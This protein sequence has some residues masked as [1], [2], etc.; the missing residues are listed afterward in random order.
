MTQ[1]EDK[2]RFD[3][4]LPIT[5]AISTCN[6]FEDLGR[7]LASLSPLRYAAWSILVVDQSDDH[8]A[9]QLAALFRE[10]SETP[11]RYVHMT[12]KGLSRA[13]NVA[14][15]E[16][17]DRIIA[18]L[19]DDCTVPLDWLQSIASTYQRHPT[20]S[21]VYGAVIPEQIDDDS[22]IPSHSVTHE[23]FYNTRCWDGP[24][25]FGIG[26]SFT[27][28]PSQIPQPLLFDVHLGA[29]ADFYGSDEHDYTLRA[30]DIGV[31][32]IETP[33]ISV[34]H[35]GG[36][37]ISTGQASTYFR[38]A[39]FGIGAMHMKHLRLGNRVAVGMILY[40]LNST[41]R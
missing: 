29:G 4:V 5:V 1:N 36:R 30:M 40:S 10:R 8:R 19:D 39:Y 14:I 21:I 41:I 28:W 3:N 34:L 23:R 18:F 27:V 32:V 33:T 25:Q 9:E 31:K 37:R 2:S 26:A 15:E 13:R 11:I 38:R 17:G 6:R 35:L 12:V 7:C 20:V 16:A 22:W 24:Q